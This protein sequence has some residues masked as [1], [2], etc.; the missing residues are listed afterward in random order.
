MNDSLQTPRAIIRVGSL[1]LLTLSIGFVRVSCTHAEELVVAHDELGQRKLDAVRSLIESGNLETAADQLTALSIELSGRLIQVDELFYRRYEQARDHLLATGTRQFREIYRARVDALSEERFKL[2]D[3]RQDHPGYRRL[4]HDE[5]H[6]TITATALE[7]VAQDAWKQGDFETARQHWSRLLTKR[8]LDPEQPFGLNHDQ[9][10]ERIIACDLFLG[11]FSTA[12]TKLKTLE[13]KSETL[14]SLADELRSNK[15]T[16]ALPLFETIERQWAGSTSSDPTHQFPLPTVIANDLLFVNIG[17]QLLGFEPRT[18]RAAWSSTEVALS[19]ILYPLGD[20]QFPASTAQPVHQPV[21]QDGFLFTVVTSNGLDE[22]ICLEIDPAEGLLAWKQNL[23]MNT[24]LSAPCVDEEYLY[25]LQQADSSPG[26]SHGEVLLVCRSIEEGSI[27]W[28]RSLYQSAGHGSSNDEERISGILMI[29]G[30]QL[31]LCTPHAIACVDI[32]FAQLEW[33]RV[34]PASSGPTQELLATTQGTLLTINSTGQTL[35]AFAADSGELM[36]QQSLPSPAKALLA[37]DDG[38]F[39]AGQELTGYRLTDG[40]PRWRI[41]GT[42]VSP[43]EP[44]ELTWFGGY[45]LW[46]QADAIMVIDPN[47]ATIRERLPLPAETLMQSA[48]LRIHENLAIFSTAHTLQ[49][50][51]RLR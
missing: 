10:R 11:E 27:R 34:F 9:I 49:V 17:A 31:Y 22:L 8:M 19:P 20:D 40:T 41:H 3:S 6:A 14:I 42:A 30:R 50:F 45:L 7:R 36:W 51:A 43:A 47:S 4:I 5:F 21:I 18:G 24:A 26:S 37:Y 33:L 35:T 29:I 12:E 13:T 48:R 16:E 38:V 15:T 39:V 46:Q 32:E 44:S 23:G 2:A 1:F 25:Q 28:R